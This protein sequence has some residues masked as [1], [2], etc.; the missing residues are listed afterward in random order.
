[1]NPVVEA[2]L[3]SQTSRASH[4]YRFD[5]PIQLAE[6]SGYVI[7][8]IKDG[9][10]RFLALPPR[11]MEVQV[12]MTALVDGRTVRPILASSHTFDLMADVLRS[13]S[14]PQEA[15]QLLRTLFLGGKH[16]ERNEAAILASCRQFNSIKSQ[17]YR[18]LDAN[19]RAALDKIVKQATKRKYRPIVDLGRE[20]QPGESVRVDFHR[21]R[22]T[23][24]ATKTAWVGSLLGRYRVPFRFNLEAVHSSH[25]TVRPP[26]GTLLGKCSQPPHWADVGTQPQNQELWYTY[27]SIHDKTKVLRAKRKAKLDKKPDD[28][29][30]FGTIRFA[31]ELHVYLVL[32]FVFG[33]LA[34]VPW[35]TWEWLDRPSIVLVNDTL[36]FRLVILLAGTTT[37]LLLSARGSKVALYHI[38]WHAFLFAGLA[39]YWILNA[40]PTDGIPHQG[41]YWPWAV[42]AVIVS[43]AIALLNGVMGF[44]SLIDK[45]K[46]GH[47]DIK[48]Q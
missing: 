13:A 44:L 32:M 33:L 10:I 17:F 1:M 4:T 39:V 26:P 16:Y 22:T 45:F 21:L 19:K 31:V 20:L 30:W 36:I 35:L 23:D 43:G 41:P 6:E 7:T 47:L 40:P 48:D 2:I 46:Y 12:E 27:L 25:F 3:F 37:T 9:P 14:A 28:P 18:R 38:G 34:I 15:I 24:V 5:S 42:L 29:A 8:N 11:K